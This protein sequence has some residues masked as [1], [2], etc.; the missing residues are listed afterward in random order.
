LINDWNDSHARE[1][2]STWK[3]FE[4]LRAAEIPSI[5]EGGVQLAIFY[6]AIDPSDIK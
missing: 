6:D 2:V 3:H 5:V 4:W 1:K